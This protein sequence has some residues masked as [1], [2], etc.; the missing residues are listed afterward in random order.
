MQRFLFVS[1]QIIWRICILTIWKNFLVL[2][3]SCL[4]SSLKKLLG[5]WFGSSWLNKI[6]LQMLCLWCDFPMGE[7]RVH[8]PAL[9]LQMTAINSTECLAQNACE[10]QGNWNIKTTLELTQNP[11]VHICRKK[12]KVN[13]GAPCQCCRTQTWAEHSLP[14]SRQK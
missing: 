9:S 2:C 14:T 12:W 3:C 11:T 5:E 8:L 10:H 4:Q 7:V 13:D 1:D 6:P